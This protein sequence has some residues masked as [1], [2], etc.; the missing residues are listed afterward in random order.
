MAARSAFAPEGRGLNEFELLRADDRESWRDHEEL[1][2]EHNP[3]AREQR[4]MVVNPSFDLPPVAAGPPASPAP[5]GE[6]L[7]EAA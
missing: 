5:G 2:D 3:D 4:A 7:P 1:R 6:N